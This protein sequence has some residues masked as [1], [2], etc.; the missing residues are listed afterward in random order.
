LTQDDHWQFKGGRIAIEDIE[1][2]EDETDLS[3]PSVYMHG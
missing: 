2:T 1:E 3:G